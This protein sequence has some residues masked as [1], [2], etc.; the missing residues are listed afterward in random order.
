VISIYFL[1]IKEGGAFLGSV[2]RGMWG[3]ERVDKG[4][5]RTLL[6]TDQSAS[7]GDRKF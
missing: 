2:N 3:G 4:G 7:G 1:Q 6:L 5:Q